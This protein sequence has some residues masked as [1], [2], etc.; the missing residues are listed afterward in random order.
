M[1]KRILTFS[2]LLLCLVMLLSSCRL[3]GIFKK[4]TEPEENEET[5][6]SEETEEPVETTEPVQTPEETV[7]P[8]ETE[9]TVEGAPEYL[10][11]FPIVDFATIH[12]S[13]DYE[14][15]EVLS[16]YASYDMNSDGTDDNILVDVDGSTQ[17]LNVSVN[18]ASGVFNIYFYRQAFLIDIDRGDDYIDLVVVDDGPADDSITYFFRYSGSEV[19]LLGSLYGTLRCNLEGQIISPDCYEWYANPVIVYSWIEIVNGSIIEHSLDKNA[20]SG[21][22]LMFRTEIG[23]GGVWMEETSTIPAYDAFPYDIAPT[24][25][26]VPAG[27]EFNILDVSDFNTSN[28]PN[29][30]YIELEDGR[31]GVFYYMRGD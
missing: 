29:W 18:D 5:E 13:T 28:K 11:T 16:A 24:N 21:Q 15:N 25:I 26:S 12:L 8:P 19:T 3:E 6:E 27:T 20:Y 10:D 30:Y 17:T 4:T 31:T 1:R 22:T 14:S 7:M 2:A 23:L 9:P